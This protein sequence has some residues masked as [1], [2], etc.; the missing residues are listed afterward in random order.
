MSAEQIVM[1]IKDKLLHLYRMQGFRK[2]ND[3]K[4]RITELETLLR[5]IMEAED[6][7]Q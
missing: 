7:K 3:L 1:I 6:G 2:T 5:E 4:I